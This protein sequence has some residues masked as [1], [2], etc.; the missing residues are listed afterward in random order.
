M[1]IYTPIDK[2]TAVP[3]FGIDA[4][5]VRI[6]T[7][8]LSTARSGERLDIT[9]TFLYAIVASSKTVSVSLAFQDQHQDPIPFSEGQF[10]SGIAFSQIYLT[11][12][13]QSGGYIKL[14][15]GRETGRGLQVQNPSSQYNDVSILKAANSTPTPAWHS[16][17]GTGAAASAQLMVAAA[18][19]RRRLIVSAPAS[20][21]AGYRVGGSDVDATHGIYLSAGQSVEILTTDAVYLW[22]DSALASVDA[23]HFYAEYD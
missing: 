15:Y 14:M 1:P 21:A 22:D 18:S 13:A 7:V 17:L 5:A 12:A 11:N 16:V 23:F 19:T 8:D 4:N 9:G 20:N 10:I 6:I 3:Q 2:I